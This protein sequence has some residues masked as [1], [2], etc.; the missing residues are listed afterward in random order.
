[1]LQ[2]PPTLLPRYLCLKNYFLLI[3][4]GVIT[5][6]ITL[7]P[8]IPEFKRNT[9]IDNTCGHGYINPNIFVCDCWDGYVKS[10]NSTICD[11]TGK[12]K[13]VAGWFQFLPW[14]GVFGVGH[15]YIGRYFIGFAQCFCTLLCYISGN[16]QEMVM[17]TG[18]VSIIFWVLS[19]ILMFSGNLQDSNDCA[20][21]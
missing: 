15:F 6:G 12:F 10:L 20:L 9:S 5:I 11:Y 1:M 8:L 7:L 18:S 16:D 17:L 2:D 14:T 3:I 19:F 4:F 13:V 21:L